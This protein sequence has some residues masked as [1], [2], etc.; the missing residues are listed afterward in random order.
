MGNAAKRL[1]AVYYPETDDTGEHELQRFIAE[2]LRP[3]IAAWM[4]RLARVTRAGADTFF[5]FE[6]GNPKRYRAPDVYVID[7]VSQDAPEPP[8]TPSTAPPGRRVLH[9][10][11]LVLR[12]LRRARRQ[13][14]TTLLPVLGDL[15][16]VFNV[17]RNGGDDGAPEPAPE[18]APTPA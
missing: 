5:Y 8:V 17:A 15:G 18:P 13:H 4:Q 12:G 3:L 9:V 1:E 10:M 14:P 11:G 16:R 7:G 6:E 2:L